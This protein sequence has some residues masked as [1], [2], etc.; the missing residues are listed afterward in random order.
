MALTDTIDL[1]DDL[2]AALADSRARTLS[3]VAP[4]DDAV[5]RRQHDPL[6]SPLVWDLAHVANYEDYWLVRAL[7]GSP[8]RAGID[9]L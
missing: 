2:A 3:L 4:Y 1:A 7:G 8:T 6:M 5:L 9:D